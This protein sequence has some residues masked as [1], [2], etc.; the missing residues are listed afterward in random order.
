MQLVKGNIGLKWDDV[1][2][3]I[4]NAKIPVNVKSLGS[5]NYYLGKQVEGIIIDGMF[6]I[7]AEYHGLKKEKWFG[8]I[9]RDN[10]DEELIK[11]TLIDN[12]KSGETLAINR[13]EIKNY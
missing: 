8:F 1:V 10:I 2:V 9:S 5:R 11:I 7:C 12:E 4:D 13:K 3:E 6:N